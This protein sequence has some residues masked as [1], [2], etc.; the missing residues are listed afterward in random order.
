MKPVIWILHAHQRTRVQAHELQ[1]PAGELQLLN[2]DVAKTQSAAVLLRRF[3][4]APRAQIAAQSA[5]STPC[6]GVVGE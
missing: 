2:H 6:E 4:A 1:Q 5:A 3:R